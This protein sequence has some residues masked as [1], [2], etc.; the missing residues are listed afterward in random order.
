M[1]AG[2]DRLRALLQRDGC[3]QAPGCYDAVSALLLAKSGFQV[4]HLSGAIASAVAL[5]LPDLGY[6]HGSTIAEV[7]Q[8]VTSVIDLPVIADADTGYGNALHAR[9]T[10]EHY[11]HIGLAGLHLED[12]VNPKRCGHMAGKEV[13][14]EREAAQKVRAVVEADTGLVVIART[15][16]MS[17]L[18]LQAAIDRAGLYHQAGADLVFL[19][20][21]TDAER[22]AEVSAALPQCRFMVNVSE[23]DPHLQP[24]Q[25]DELAAFNVKIALYPVAPLLSAAQALATLYQA[26]AK[27][28]TAQSVTKLRWDELTDLLGQPA[29]LDMESRYSS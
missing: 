23:A 15:D 6:I 25:P 12:Q 24:L 26:I 11:A 16:A 17:V 29:L 1:T 13:I 18:G 20:G 10:A 2:S 21:V 27:E 22:L 8:R 4:A 19:E 28:G 9:H 5:G 3:L 14:D 7:A